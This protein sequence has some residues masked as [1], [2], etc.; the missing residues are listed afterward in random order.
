MARKLRREFPGACYQ[1]I[2]RGNGRVGPFGGAKTPRRVRALPVR[3]LRPLAEPKMAR[4][5]RLTATPDRNVE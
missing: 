2:N 4:G 5:E 3:S 1:V